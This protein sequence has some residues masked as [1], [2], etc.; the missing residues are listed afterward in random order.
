[1]EAGMTTEQLDGIRSGMRAMWGAVAPAWAEHADYVDARAEVVTAALLDRTRPGADDRV[2]ELAC[3]AGGLGLAAARR[4]REVVVSDVVPAMVETATK[5][6]A[7]LG[8][9]NVSGR[10]LDLEAIEEPDGAYDVVVC[11]EGLM[12][13]PEP[14]RAV[15]EL[16]RVLRPGT[17]RVAVAVWGARERNPWLGILLDAVTA[18]V[19]H[20][21]PPPGVP[22]PF[23]LADA[24]RLEGL[25]RDAGLEDVRVEELAAPLRLPSFDA[26]WSR[27][28]DLAG[29]LALLLRAQPPE[30][31]EAIRDRARAAM[32]SYAGED[33]VELPGLTLV[34][35]GRASAT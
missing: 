33:G 1:M 34:A 15:R 27:T 29:P 31:I 18:Q 20:P 8:L 19:G 16:A 28:I 25:F 23:A 5:R 22:G 12:F 11:R 14:D 21:V 35:S 32:A 4:A 2:L 17:G 7:D 24:G 3:G 13:A 30:A 9:A 10:V 26:W 6:A